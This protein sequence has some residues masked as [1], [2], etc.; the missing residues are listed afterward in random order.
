M[1]KISLLILAFVIA[2]TYSCKKS[3]LDLSNPNEPG[4][5]A[6]QSE[7]GIKR[8]ALGVYAKFD[9]DYWW[10]S[11]QNH[12]IMGD[13]YF[14][15]VGN[16]GWRWVNQP[17][18]ITTS[19]GTV[20]TPP[21]GGSQIVE[22][23]NRNSRAFG[24]DNAFQFEWLSMYLVNNQANLVLASVEDPDLSLSGNAENK[25]AILRAWGHWWKGFTY[26]RIGSL[27]I[28]G[29]I[30]NTLNET[31]DEFV[32][33]FEMVAEANRQF[34][35]A[36]DAL[37]GV[38]ANEE[39][40]AFFGDLIPSFTK[41]GK[42]GVLSPEEWIRNMNTY[43]A[44]N[45]LVSKEV[46]DITAEEWQTIKT[47]TDNGIK[48]SDKIFTMRS[49][50][51]NDLVSETAWQPYR[52]AV[53]LWSEIS[54]RLIQDFK[55]GDKR[56]DRNFTTEEDGYPLINAQGRGF[57]YSTRYAFKLIEEGG[58]YASYTAGLAEIPVA[59]SYEENALMQ[60][61]VLIKTGQIDAGLKFI[62]DVRNYQNAGL[63]SVSGTGLNAEQAYEELRRERRIGLLNKNVSFYDARRWGVTKPV[64][65][66]GGRK[67]AV[68]LY[69]P[70]GSNTPIVDN[71]A[72]INYNYLSWWDVP[73]NELDFNTPSSTSAPVKAD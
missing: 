2:S 57:N 42:G 18:S 73:E 41:V 48:N 19:N 4:I 23:R 44:R 7:E 70:A 50:L 17:T 33:H 31:N 5:P 30:A 54:E 68:V 11:L 22:L 46:N 62:D 14:A 38:T 63:A 59:A 45:I 55:P 1:K 40:N 66:G 51:E 3:S 67:N 10:L 69:T 49:A 15:S 32:T 65:Q 39:Y 8:A 58:D 25:K 60:A 52:S 35:L 6:L 12:D 72:T 24:D 61:E 64:E 37:K 27:Y 53:Y 28:S 36:I 16:F 56:F 34:D 13:S 20:L 21:Q 71:N 26:S 29:I 43:K 47:L 9:L